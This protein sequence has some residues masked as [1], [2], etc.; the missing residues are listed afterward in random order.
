MKMYENL[1]KINKKCYFSS[2]LQRRIL[3]LFVLSDSA[4]TQNFEIH[5]LR[6]FMQIYSK[7]TKNA[8]SLFR[9]GFDS[10]RFI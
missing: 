2:I 6:K 4:W 8:T 3:I 7:S 5:Q 10:V 9:S 1:F